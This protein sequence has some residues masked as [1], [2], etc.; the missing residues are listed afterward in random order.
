MPAFKAVIDGSG[1]FPSQML[2]DMVAGFFTGE[3]E[4]DIW[5]TLDEDGPTSIELAPPFRTVRSVDCLPDGAQDC[6]R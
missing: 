2:D 5:L 6:A 4:D 3:A 1:L